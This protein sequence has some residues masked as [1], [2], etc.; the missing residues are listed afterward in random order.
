M[1]NLINELNALNLKEEQRKLKHN[2]ANKRW[3]E[4]N[5]EK[6]KESTK[7]YREENPEKILKLKRAYN[8]KNKEQIHNKRMEQMASRPRYICNKC[9]GNILITS[10]EKHELLC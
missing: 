3:R 5:Q 1:D 6:I 7:K 2:E 9:N 4:K 10:K 8:E